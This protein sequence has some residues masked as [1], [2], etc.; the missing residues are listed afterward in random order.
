MTF[1]R[2]LASFAD[3]AT[4]NVSFR[5]ILVNGAMQIAQRGTSFTGITSGNN[6]A[7]DRWKFQLNTQGTW[8]QSQET[9]APTGSGFIKSTKLLCTTADASPASGDYLVFSQAL[10]G[11]NLQQLR[12]GTSSAQQITLSFWVKSNV[13]GTYITEIRDQDNTRQICK[14]YTISTSGTWE[15]K[16]LTFAGDIT[17]AL[18]NDSNL[19]LFPIWWLGAGS[20]FTSGTLAT[21]WAAGTD[22]NKA[23]GQTNVAAAINNYWQITGVQMEIGPAPTPFEFRPYYIEL[24]QCQRY[25]TELQLALFLTQSHTTTRTKGNLFLPTTMR[26]NPTATLDNTNRITYLGVL[27]YNGVYTGSID[28]SSK[29]RVFVD[30][31]RSSGDSWTANNPLTINA[32]GGSTLIKLSSEI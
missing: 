32:T 8:T 7:T 3:N 27:D 18:D 26:G 30:Y 22:A 15:Y 11:Q 20:N 25:Y 17:G 5:N 1:A 19:S 14:S 10:E 2:D 4:Q 28:T 12:K 31:T 24:S 9:D 13:T 29:E 6:Y 23:V 21:S 16:T